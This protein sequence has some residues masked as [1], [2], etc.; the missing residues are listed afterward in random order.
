MHDQEIIIQLKAG[1]TFFFEMIFTEYH[2]KVYFF[3]FHKTRSTFIA[4]E[5]VQET[6]IKL[7]KYKTSLNDSIYLSTQIFHIARSVMIDIL[8][9]D[10]N[11]KKKIFNSSASTKTT[12]NNLVEKL[13]LND[14][15]KQAKIAVSKMPAARRKVFEMSRFKG[16]SHQEIAKELSLSVKTVENH[17]TQ[18]LKQ[19][20]RS[21]TWFFLI[22]LLSSVLS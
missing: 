19:L 2:A 1:D 18:A 7:W 3:V 8:R 14:L 15:D 21:L 11:Y 13:D 5:T 10:A 17:I 12:T 22:L 20:R 9:K 16:M 6:F 4:E